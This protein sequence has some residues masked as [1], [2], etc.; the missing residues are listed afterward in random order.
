MKTVNSQNKDNKTD[1]LPAFSGWPM[2]IGWAGMLIFAF[3][4]CTHMVAAGDTWVALACGRHFIEHGVNTAEP[5]SANSHKPGPTPQEVQ[6]WPAA[7]RWIADKAGLETVK[8]WHPTGWINQNWLTHVIFY[9]L[10]TKSPIADAETLSFNSLVYWKIAIY[11]IA[12]AVVFYAGRAL[13]V[14]PALSAVFAC[15][16]MF[17]GRSFLDIRPAGFSNMLVAVFL[18]ILILATYRNIL[19]IWLVVPLVTL[20]CNIHGGYIYVFIMLVPFIGIHLLTSVSKKVF[21]TIGIKGVCHSVAA[22]ITAFFAMIL[23]NPF[24]LTNLTHTL[25]ISISKHAEKWRTVNEWHPAFE[26]DNPVGDETA[27]LIM[28][29]I[30]WIAVVIWLISSI[31]MS[32]AIGRYSKRRTAGPDEYQRPKADAALLFIVAMTVYMAICSR[33][34]IPIAAVAAC[35]LIAMLID[36]TIRSISVILNMNKIGRPVVSPVSRRLR[37]II[38]ASCVAILLTFGSWCGWKFKAIYLD[39]WPSDP[40]FCSVF[41]RMTASGS[42]PFYACRFIN[43]NKLTGNMFNY[44]TEGGFIAW[45]QQPDP[46]TGRTPLQ[47]F[48]DGRAQAAYDPKA[49]DDWADIMAGGDIAQAAMIRGEDLTLEDYTKIGEYI[50]KRLKKKDVWIILMPSFQFDSP[51]FRGIE[52]N[53]DWRCVYMDNIQKISVD[54]TN[55]QGKRL[56]EGLFSGQTVFPDEFTRYL[57]LAHNL[58][59][60][61]EGDDAKRDGLDYAIKA[62]NLNPSQ[63]PILKVI[64]AAR[65]PALKAEVD[66]FCG[67]YFESFVKNKDLLAKKNGY[68]NSIIAALK[69]CE[70]LQTSAKMR[71]DMELIKSYE[72]KHAE[73]AKELNSITEEKRW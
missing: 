61:T 15:F 10:S 27:F 1:S 57:T 20:W 62:F 44:W 23:F 70:Y 42:K 30:A 68:R 22:G 45:A 66:S 6:T 25:E 43:C 72:I 50:N 26:W 56:F 2:M 19:Y 59:L 35:P 38:L 69:A 7:A 51:L 71:K 17:I 40:E 18:L 33:R 58:L 53:G 41:M 14:N 47:L 46:S 21:V 63:Q 24:H 5:F 54:I 49:Y 28:Y 13:G 12:V 9:W 55:P 37:D 8:Y 64:H 65:F 32:R 39:P 3:H 67:Q 48:M 36:Q 34:F 16:A 11:V 60:N 73:Y 4:A 52:R 29:I 31:L